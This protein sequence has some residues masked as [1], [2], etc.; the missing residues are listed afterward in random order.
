MN[1]KSWHIVIAGS[2]IQF[3][4]TIWDVFERAFSNREL[5]TTLDFFLGG[6]YCKPL[7][8]FSTAEIFSSILYLFPLS[9]LV[10]AAILYHDKT[11]K[12]RDVSIVLGC[13]LAIF[14]DF[15]LG[16]SLIVAGILPSKKYTFT[17]LKQS[18][19][20]IKMG[21]IKSWYIASFGAIIQFS[22]G[23]FAMQK[24]ESC[25]GGC[26]MAG[27][28]SFIAVF[29][30]FSAGVLLIS[31]LFLKNDSTKKIGAIISIVLGAIPLFLM[32]FMISVE[33]INFELFLFLLII[34]IRSG[35]FLSPLPGI[36]Y[37]IKKV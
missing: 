27:I 4:F 9:G 33:G 36:Y 32:L 29:L 2:F 16:I 13:I 34:T 7:Y 6:I 35:I 25:K 3:F 17:D 8:L 1:L 30:Y 23:N 10:F 21:G 22:L 26:D 5:C 19:S 18:I 15:L 11:R 20:S 31:A 28:D 12:L 24:Y 14:S 37:F